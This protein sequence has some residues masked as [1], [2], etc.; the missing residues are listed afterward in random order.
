M[1]YKH[2]YTKLDNNIYTTIRR[3]K[4]GNV[5]D[6]ITEKCPKGSYRAK[7]IG[8]ERNTLNNLSLEFLQRDT[9]LSNRTEIYRLFQSFYRNPIDFENEK[10]WIYTM[11]KI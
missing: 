8:L 6:I 7:I 9:D 5:G 10:F 1:N 11:E 4:N 2:N 3:R